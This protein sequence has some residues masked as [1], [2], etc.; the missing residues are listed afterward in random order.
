MVKYALIPRPGE[1]AELVANGVPSV[2]DGVG[3]PVHRRAVPGLNKGDG[4]MGRRFR[5]EPGSRVALPPSPA[6][7]AA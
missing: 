3:D 1:G 7:G 5:F 6:F 4:F 2:A